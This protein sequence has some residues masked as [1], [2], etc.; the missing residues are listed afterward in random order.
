MLDYYLRSAIAA[1]RLLDQDRSAVPLPPVS[2]AASPAE[3]EAL[4]T[5]EEAFAWFD[6][7]YL[8]IAE[9]AAVAASQGHDQAA[10]LL[11]ATLRSFRSG[12]G[13]WPQWLVALRSALTAAERLGDPY[14]QAVSHHG[15]GKA[16]IYLGPLGHARSHLVKALD[17][18]RQAGDK[19]GESNACFSM[20]RLYE[21]NGDLDSARRCTERSLR[22]CQHLDSTAEHA[23]ALSAM[24]WYQ[25]RTGVY[26]EAMDNCERALALHR[27]RADRIGI[28]ITLDSLAL[29]HRAAGDHRRAAAE[30]LEAIDGLRTAA[31]GPFRAEAL[32]SLGDTFRA[33]GDNAS[34]RRSW[35]QA[36]TIL[37]ELGQ[38]SSESVRDRLAA[39]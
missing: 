12:K 1:D 20:A 7:E 35:Q 16:L 8:V 13:K 6:R 30:Y 22:L 23:H 27:D 36:M 38:P 4:G 39:L 15:L 18:Y 31:D 10:W 21:E 28:A 3:P 24:G 37:E 14:A 25:L 11:P 17:W 5:A 19:V 2:P 29:G 33:A 34:A 9:L 26:P 32:T